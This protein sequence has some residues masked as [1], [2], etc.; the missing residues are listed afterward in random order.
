MTP[1]SIDGGDILFICRLLPSP[2]PMSTPDFVAHQPSILMFDGGYSSRTWFTFFL[3]FFICQ[4]GGL[5]RVVKREPVWPSE[6][7]SD[8]SDYFRLCLLPLQ[9]GESLLSFPTCH[10]HVSLQGGPSQDVGRLRGDLSSLGSGTP[11]TA[12]GLSSCTFYLCI[13]LFLL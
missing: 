8:T 4:S 2:P 12:G 6:N 3:F 9:L 1:I 7:W 10:L 13:H 11:S 5:H